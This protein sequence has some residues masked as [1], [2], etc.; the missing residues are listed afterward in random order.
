MSI[1]TKIYKY[2]SAKEANGY[3][4]EDFS[5]YVLQTPEN[6]DNLED[7]LD[8]FNITLAGLPFRKEFAPKTGFIIEL[9]DEDIDENGKMCLPGK[10]TT[11]FN[12][13]FNR[14]KDVGFNGALLIEAYSGD[15]VI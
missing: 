13:L 3:K 8:T 15:M 2:S 12:D 10:G 6:Q 4:G 7:T 5:Q 11:D 9:Y 14:L 1:V